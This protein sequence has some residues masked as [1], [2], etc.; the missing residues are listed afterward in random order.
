VLKLYDTYGFH[1]EFTTELAAEKG[2]F[3]DMD[4]FNRKFGVRVLGE[5]VYQRGSNITAE[6]LRFKEHFELI[7]YQ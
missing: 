1:I 6:R 2:Y 3:V 4:G 5:S 7:N